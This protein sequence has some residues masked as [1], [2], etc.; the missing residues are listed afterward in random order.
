MLKH[1][2][3]TTVICVFLALFMVMAILAPRTFLTVLNIQSMAS[4]LPEL[5][6]LSLG[7]MVVIVTGGI[8]LSIVYVA[9]LSG[10]AGA[11]VMAHG[12]T[13]QLSAWGTYLVIAEGLLASLIVAMLCG[14]L[15]GFVIAR[16]GVSPI[17]ATLGTMTL[18]EGIGLQ[19]TRGGSVTGFPPEYA[20]IGSGTLL[21][22]PV[23]FVILIICGFLTSILLDRTAWGRTV[24]M[25]G[26]NP[27]ATLFSGINVRKVAL[28]VYLYSAFM[29]W[30]A[31]VIMTSRYNS[32]RIDY[33][34]SY[35]LQTV[36][37]V[38][39]GGADIS[40][41]YAR[42]VSTIVAVGIIQ[43]ISSGLNILGVN[44]Y[45]V[46]VIIGLI[47]IGV[48]LANSLARGEAR[49]PQLKRPPLTKKGGGIGATMS[50]AGLS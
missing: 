19:F 18:F 29:S 15:N 12:F 11:Y 45:I 33:G 35:L 31:G 24:Y 32:A 40:G 2:K 47:L 20:T 14:L 6:I 42:V 26:H 48:L 50:K 3:E 37:A 10:I 38:V 4:Q 23:P 5:A 30:L 7:M 39:L 43:I 36:T 22:I 1:T 25:L 9:S 13:D 41:G 28:K 8:D 46:D 21:M 17:L 44:R 16:I 34:T 27:V 49:V